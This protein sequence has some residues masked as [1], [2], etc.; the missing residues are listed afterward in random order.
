[1][2]IATIDVEIVEKVGNLQH[3]G[4]HRKGVNIFGRRREGHI[5]R[6]GGCKGLGVLVSS[7]AAID[8]LHFPEALLEFGLV[9]GHSNLGFE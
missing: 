7:E 5:L 2:I 9:G 4:L 1:M 6:M 8:L 3:V